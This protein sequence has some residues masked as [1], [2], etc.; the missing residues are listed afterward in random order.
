MLRPTPLLVL[1]PLG[2]RTLTLASH[3]YLPPGPKPGSFSGPAPT[4]GAGPNA[5]APPNAPAGI[6]HASVASSPQPSTPTSTSPPTSNA[7]ETSGRDRATAESPDL[8]A[9]ERRLVEGI[10]RVDHA[11]ELGANWIYRGQK[12]ACQ[13]RG[14]HGTAGQVEQM[15]DNERHHLNVLTRVADQH[16]VRPTALYP[17]WQ[18]LAWG[19]GAA[20]ALMGKEA[21]MACTEAVETVI[22]EHYD[23][24]LRALR[25]LI[26]KPDA[27][28][29]LPLLA[30]VLEEFRDDELE[31]LDTA[32]EE[33]ALKAPGHS[34]LSA[35]VAA[36][37][38]VGIT[39][40]EKV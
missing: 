2:A 7:P 18:G 33:G 39:V 6:P 32:V 19:L 1:R 8:S 5:T 28:P 27:H 3:A 4:A 35:V 13:I 31:H 29:S 9:T 34:L 36:A 30:K 15:W 20:M 21:A 26:A 14:D 22:G 25:P 11:G 38:R 40:A 10:V 24:Q 23:D 17:V 12:W 37:C 16:R